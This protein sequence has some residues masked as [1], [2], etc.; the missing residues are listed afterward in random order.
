M[1][2][3][4]RKTK[5]SV[6]VAGPQAEIEDELVLDEPQLPLQE[7]LGLD[8]TV[9]QWLSLVFRLLL[10]ATGVIGLKVYEQR[11]IN[12]LNL[13][14]NLLS[15]EISELESK[16]QKLK[17]DIEGF[18]VLSKQSKQF[19]TKLDI[20]QGIMDD[21]IWAIKG[22]DQIRSSIPDKVWLEKIGYRDKVFT[23]DGVSISNKEIERFVAALENTQLF[24]QVHLGQMHEKEQTV[25]NS[26]GRKQR[27]AYRRF[28]TVQSTLK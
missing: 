12:Q 19:N 21:R 9:G 20:I 13:S 25:R 23:I 6:G 3:D 22:L 24:S 5:A 17:K 27:G 18:G 26:A 16:K 14:K 4:I 2:I 1:K 10:L 8:L 28:F 15:G 7:R 11:N